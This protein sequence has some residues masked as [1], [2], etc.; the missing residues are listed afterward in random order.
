MIKALAIE[1]LDA[2]LSVSEAMGGL[3][4]YFRRLMLAR[5]YGVLQWAEKALRGLCARRTSLSENEIA[6]LRPDDVH[7]IMSSLA[8]A[9]H[10]SMDR[11]TVLESQ[12]HVAKSVGSSRGQE[13]PSQASSNG[14]CDP[15]TTDSSTEFDI[16]RVDME[17]PPVVESGMS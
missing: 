8:E 11:M 7:E 12:V 17:V 13:A 6:Q 3:D 9:Y 14:I 15:R 5:T 2:I 4:P 16:R 1:R 10:D